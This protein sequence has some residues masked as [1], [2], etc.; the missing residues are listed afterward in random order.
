MNEYNLNRDQIEEFEIDL[1]RTCNLRCPLCT[2]N[3]VHAKYLLK[4]N[5]RKIDEITDQLDSFVGLKRAFIAG[6]ISEPTLY[7]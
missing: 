4:P 3:Y 7:P 6:A 5:I 1:T 2:R